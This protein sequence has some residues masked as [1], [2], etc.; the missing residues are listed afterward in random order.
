VG[1]RPPAGRGAPDPSGALRGTN[2]PEA[3]WNN[4]AGT[5]G[6]FGHRAK[7]RYGK[8]KWF[9][10]SKEDADGWYVHRMS[11]EHAER[12]LARLKGGGS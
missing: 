5:L 11:N 10:D 12:A 9:T 7:S 4:V 8:D 3:N 2:K 1:P 6:A